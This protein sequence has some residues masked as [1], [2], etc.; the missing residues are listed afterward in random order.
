VLDAVAALATGGSP[1]AAAKL[2]GS[3]SADRAVNASDTLTAL[4]G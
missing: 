2:G 1:R 3:F 4:K